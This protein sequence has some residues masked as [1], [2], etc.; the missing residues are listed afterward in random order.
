MS[1]QFFPVSGS[2]RIEP[3]QDGSIMQFGPGGASQSVGALLLHFS[4]GLNWVGS[5]AVMGRSSQAEATTNL[6]GFV[7]V[8]Y[9]ALFLNMA[10]PATPYALTPGSTLLTTTSIIQ[11]PANLT[12]GML[13][14]CQS[15][16]GWLYVTDLNGCPAV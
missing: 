16:F 2:I 3:S 7:P 8:P 14:N 4:A 10:E 1:A 5:L 6:V 12:I 11:V 15:G 13:V 9:R